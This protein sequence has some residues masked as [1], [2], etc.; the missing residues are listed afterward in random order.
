M[1]ECSCKVG[2]EE[3]LPLLR[4]GHDAFRATGAEILRPFQLSVLG[5]AYT[6][7][8][9]FEEAHAALDEGL[10]LA[11]KNDDRVQ[12]AELH[13]LKGELLL[14][15][16]PDQAAAAEDRFTQAIETARRQQSKAWELRATIE[17]RPPLAAAGAPRRSPRHVGR[18]SRHVHRRSDDAGPRG[19]RRA[20]GSLGLTSITSGEP[21]AVMAKLITQAAQPAS[22]RF[23][24][25]RTQTTSLFLA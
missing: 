6:Q 2:L 21:F 20:A 1:P 22:A 3:S 25:E 12:E 19:S 16:S 4:K 17:S 15:E 14:A 18:H 8:A 5:D 7:A 11:E 10:A 24:F 9:R 13:R 23:P